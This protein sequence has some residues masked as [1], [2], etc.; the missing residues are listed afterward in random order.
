MDNLLKT[1]NG[2][3]TKI[4]CYNPKLSFSECK[5]ASGKLCSGIPLLHVITTTIT[6]KNECMKFSYC[7][8]W[9]KNEMMM[10]VAVIDINLSSSITEV[11]NTNLFQASLNFFK[12][13]LLALPQCKNFG[14]HGS[15]KTKE[16]KHFKR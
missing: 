10:T 16:T 2:E 6:N 14:L 8:L 3:S 4:T 12:V 13:V 7:E 1:K 15:H 5:A 9:K 11:M